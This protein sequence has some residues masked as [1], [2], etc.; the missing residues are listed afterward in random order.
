MPLVREQTGPGRA[1]T[2][3]IAPQQVSE[4]IVGWLF[5]P[6]SHIYPHTTGSFSSASFS[7]PGVFPRKPSPMHLLTLG[8]GSRCSIQALG[9]DWLEAELAAIW[10]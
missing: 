6:Y 9:G 4:Q 1:G 10:V 5:L 3:P 2:G 8:R 7:R